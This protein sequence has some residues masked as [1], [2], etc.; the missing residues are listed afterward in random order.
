MKMYDANPIV[1]CNFQCQKNATPPQEFLRG[2]EGTLVPDGYSAYHVMEKMVPAIMVSGCWSHARRPFATVIKTLGKEKAK[3]T[4]AYDAIKQISA[5][6]K[7]EKELAKLLPEERLL[8]CQLTI[9]PLIKAFFA[10]V[11]A[12]KDKVLPQRETD[13]GFIYQGRLNFLNHA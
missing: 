12:H 5:I 13:K 8:G 3:R 6:F 11:K 7:L 1:L 10:W 4:L 9:H 2:Y